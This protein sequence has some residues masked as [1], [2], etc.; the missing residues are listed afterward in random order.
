MRKLLVAL[1][2]ASALVSGCT[3]T[4][5]AVKIQ[6][7]VDVAASELGAG[8]VVRVNVVDQR[9][10]TTIGTR[11]ARGVGADMTIDGDLRDIF[12]TAIEAGLARQGFTL[13]Q[14][15]S[16]ER[17]L[18]VEVRNLDYD[19]IVGFWA[20]TLKVDCSLNAVCRDG[21]LRPYEEMHRG[22]FTESVQVVQG[23]EANNKYVS[24]AVSSA[25]NSLLA[26]QQLLQCLA[27]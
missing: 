1:V 20:G 18:R 10:K 9:P 14:D 22:Q 3:F 17:E 24:D 12:R 4:H 13:T 19:V 16:A 25:V 5:Q 6:P 15:P 2:L 23:A 21:D 11:G 26:D 27:E 7:Q 8:R